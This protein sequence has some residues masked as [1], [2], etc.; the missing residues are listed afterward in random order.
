MYNT[1]IKQASSADIQDFSNWLA[2]KTGEYNPGDPSNC[3]VCQYMKARGMADP[4]FSGTDYLTY[5]HGPDDRVGVRLPTTIAEI[6]YGKN[7]MDLN[8]SYIEFT[9]QAARY[10]AEK[11]LKELA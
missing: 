4:K 5:T 8:K 11:V 2:N 3:L 1:V 9:F 7:N 6:A 10:R